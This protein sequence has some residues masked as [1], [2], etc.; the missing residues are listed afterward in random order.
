MI[1]RVTT[2]LVSEK[3]VLS[4]V[5]TKYAKIETE[6]DRLAEL[7]PRAIYEWKDA[8][9]ECQMREVRKRIQE[10]GDNHEKLMLLTSKYME[11]QQLK[12]QFAKYLGER[13]IAPRK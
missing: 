3:H 9:L 7:V 2:D 4:K 1:R 8:I 13:I 5:H 12:G 10:V 11:L 6:Q